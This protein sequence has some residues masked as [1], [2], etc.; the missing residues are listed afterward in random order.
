M[1][2]FFTSDTHFSH[3]NILEFENR[4]FKTVPE[5]DIA[6]IN[7]WNEQVGE[8]DIVYFLG[9]FCLST[10]ERTVEILKQLKGRKIFIKGNHDHSKTWDK[11]MSRNDS[12]VE[13]FY[14]I[15]HKIKHMKNEIWL[16]HYP[17]EIGLRPRKWSLSGHIHSEESS[18]ANQIN[19]GVDSPHFKHLNKPFGSLITL[20]E[21]YE[22]M[23]EREADIEEVFME[24]RGR[25]KK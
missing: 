15:G 20:E 11:I 16:T 17:M 6:M 25:T 18:Y 13:E 19:V 24:M 3:K 8:K 10:Y 7:I 12:L 9:D 4:P 1:N 14:P 21:I 5:M 22:V 2:T 23:Q